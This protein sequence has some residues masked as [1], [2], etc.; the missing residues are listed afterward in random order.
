[1]EGY[2]NQMIVETNLETIDQKLDKDLKEEEKNCRTRT[3]E[4]SWHLEFREIDK[5]TKKAFG[6]IKIGKRR[7]EKFW[8]I[9]T[10]Q[11]EEI[12]TKE[13]KLWMIL[14]LKTIDKKYSMFEGIEEPT[15]NES[16]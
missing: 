16:R 11:V 2:R 10:R 3:D 1:M 7:S 5:L 15:K 13:A 8:K 6:S 9:W 14:T 12:G 4:R